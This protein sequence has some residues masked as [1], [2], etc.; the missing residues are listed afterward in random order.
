MATGQLDVQTQQLDNQNTLVADTVQG[1]DAGNLNL[2]AAIVNNQSGAIRSSQNSQLNIS[3]QLNNQSGEISAVKQLGIQGD[4]LAINNLNGQLLAG[5]NLNINAKSLTGDGRV[6]SLGNADIQ[7]KDSYQHN[8]TAQL[9]ANQN[10]S[11]TSAG[12]INNDGV[13]NAGNQLQLSAVNISNSSNAKIESHDTQLTAQ[14]QLN[15]TGLINGDLTT[16]TAD[17]V[18][19]QGTG[20][21]LERT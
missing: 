10:L 4:Q 17:T 8:A 16:L 3:Q 5:E 2:N 6:L 19:N 12:D 15:N 13:I 11:L 20:R 1:I 18:N 9:Q 7:L 21:I 14:Q